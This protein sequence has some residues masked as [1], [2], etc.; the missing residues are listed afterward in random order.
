MR[1]ECHPERV[2]YGKGLC[3]PCYLT[4][5]RAANP[6]KVKD[7]Q[8]RVRGKRVIQRKLGLRAGWQE[9]AARNRVHLREARFVRKYGLTLAEHDTLAASQGGLCAICGRERPLRVDHDHATGVIRGLLCHNCNVALGL[10][11]E[12][13]QVISLAAQYVAARQRL[14]A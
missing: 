2:H 3:S 1:A 5:W 12:D 6:E 8:S 14:S 4:Q 10:L 13:A 11:G 7:Q 9:W